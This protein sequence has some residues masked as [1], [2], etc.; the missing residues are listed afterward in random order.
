MKN[1]WTKLIA[2][3][4]TSDSY[5]TG[6]CKTKQKIFIINP[7]LKLENDKDVSDW[8]YFHSIIIKFTIHFPC[9]IWIGSWLFGLPGA[10]NGTAVFKG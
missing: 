10:K 7:N 6:Q 2:V 1:W 5:Q 4:D 9:N 3:D 8:L